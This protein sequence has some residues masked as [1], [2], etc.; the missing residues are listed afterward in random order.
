MT[1]LGLGAALAAAAVFGFASIAQAEAVRRATGTAGRGSPGAFLLRLLAVPQFWLA[2]ALNLV[3]FLLHLVS[4][5]IVPLYLSQAGI[6]GSLAVTAV[7]AV[8]V[9]GERL[10]RSDWFAVAAVCFGLAVLAAASGDIGDT[11][12]ARPLEAWL[13]IAA[14]GVAIVGA[15]VVR[16]SVPYAAPLL[17]LLAGLGFAGSGLAARLLPDLRPADLLSDPATYLLPASGALAFALYSFALRR[18]SITAATAPMIVAQTVVPAVAGVALL[19]DELR[20]GWLPAG[21]TGF[22]LTAAG[23]VALARFESGRQ[24]AP[25]AVER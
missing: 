3:G 12:S 24:P 11:D 18:G 13:A 10:S 21:L 19:G 16:S 2:I 14:V 25:H 17:G 1:L 9:L 7:L 6:A 5:R 22:V 4:L 8:L 20:T 15:A 23:A